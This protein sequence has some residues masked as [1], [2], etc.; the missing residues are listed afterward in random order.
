MSTSIVPNDAPATVP[1]TKQIDKRLGIKTV[2]FVLMHVVCLAAIFTGISLPAVLLCIGLYLVRM[3][4]LTAGFH[5]YFSHRSFKTSRVFQFVLAWI[6]TSAVQ[7]GPLWW[8]AHH[9]RHHKYS[10]KEGDIHSPVIESFWRSSP[11][12]G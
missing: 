2:P 9:R 1:S 5:R 3:W 11:W 4:G 10:D 12:A 7:K 8:A 6:G